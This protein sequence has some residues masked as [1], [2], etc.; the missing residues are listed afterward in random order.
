VSTTTLK[1]GSIS[2]DTRDFK[3]FARAL[4]KAEPLLA[5]SMRTKLR[6]AGQ[7]VA[8]EAKSNVDQYSSTIAGTIK[9]R[10]SGTTVSVVAK[11]VLAGLFEMGNKGSSGG[12]TFRHPVFGNQDV[13]VNQKMHPFLSKA[14]ADKEEAAVALIL[15]A[16]EEAMEAICAD[17]EV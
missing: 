14:L 7:L 2:V 11:G 15:D 5:K 6:A 17:T 8:D 10:T 12:G 3:S 4:R 13:W 1:S 9:V 16:L